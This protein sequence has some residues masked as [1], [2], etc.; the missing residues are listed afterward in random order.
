MTG[1]QYSNEQLKII[2]SKHVKGQKKI[3]EAYS[4]CGKST[5]L[6]GFSNQRK[7]SR[8]LYLSFNKSIAVEAQGKFP[9]HVD[10][11]TMN[12][13]AYKSF[14]VQYKELISNK[15]SSADVQKLMFGISKGDEQRLVLAHNCLRVFENWCNSSDEAINAKHLSSVVETASLSYITPKMLANG[16]LEIIEAMQEGKIPV[17][18]SF[19][20]KLFQLS[21]PKLEYDVIMVDEA[22]D[23]NP[24]VI[25][26]IDRQRNRAEIILVG[27]K[28]QSIYGFRGSV[29]GM[30]DDSAEIFHLTETYRFGSNLARLAST[31]LMKYKGARKPL[32]GLGQEIIINDV[33]ETLKHQKDFGAPLVICRTKAKILESII[34]VTLENPDPPKIYMPSGSKSY[35]FSTIMDAYMLYS[36]EISR[37]ACVQYSSWEQYLEISE[38]VDDVEMSQTINLVNR[39]GAGIP[40]ALM[41]LKKLEVNKIEKAKYAITTAHKS[42]GLE[43]SYVILEN[44]FPDLLSKHN[45]TGEP[46]DEQELNL[47]YVALTRAERAIEISP[48]ILKL[49]NIKSDN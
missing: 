39:Y 13:L 24:V 9:R 49:L 19:Y 33:E 38:L 41:M 15:I 46:M 8:I 43:S 25:D 17:S 26:I 20:M 45:E 32:R 48:R 29:N 11:M 36:K 44:D 35:G 4:G 16:T 2:N 1:F 30:S 42:K 21:R 3:V 40:K 34:E 37:G 31:L 14:G 6:I 5:T 23:L 27:D 7:S 10:C 12:A 22:Q 47:V 28:H 18:H